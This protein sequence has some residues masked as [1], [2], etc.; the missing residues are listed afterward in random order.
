MNKVKALVD[1]YGVCKLEDEDIDVIEKI[2]DESELEWIDGIIGTGPDKPEG[3]NLTEDLSV[4]TC[5]T[6]FLPV[7]DELTEMFGKLVVDYNLNYSGWNFDIE[8]IESIQL[9]HYYDG[10]F[11]D[12][13]TDSFVNPVIQNDKPYNRKV[14]LS[15]FLNDPEEYEGGELDLEIRGPNIEKRYDTFK[16]PKGSVVVFPSHTWHRVRPVTSGVRKSLVLWIQG[17]PFK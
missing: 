11:Y 14:S 4:R 7:Y 6:C 17:P 9:S 2:L 8:F 5:K 1:P 3:D 12:W 15:V 16:L 13:H 10:H